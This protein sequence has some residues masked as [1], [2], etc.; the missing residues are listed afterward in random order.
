[1]DVVKAC[2][3]RSLEEVKKFTQFA[4]STDLTKALKLAIKK[5]YLEIVEY[6]ASVNVNTKIGIKI[7]FNADE[8]FPFFLACLHG[9]I[10]IV[11]FLLS[12]GKYNLD[13]PQWKRNM[14]GTACESGHL[15]LAEY[16]CS[17]WDIDFDLERTFV[18]CCEFGNLEMVEFLESLFNIHFCANVAFEAACGGGN[19]DIARFL[20]ENQGR[21]FD[22]PAAFYT[23]CERGKLNSMEFLLNSGL[24][25]ESYD[26]HAFANV[27]KNGHL[28]VVERMLE[29]IPDYR[30][31]M[32]ALDY[33]C[34]KSNLELIKFL[35]NQNLEPNAESGLFRCACG[36]RQTRIVEYLLDNRLN[37]SRFP[38]HFQHE[39][40]FYIVNQPGESATNQYLKLEEFE[41]FE[42]THIRKE[43]MSKCIDAFREHC[44]KFR[45]K[46]ARK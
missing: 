5:G 24:R 36:Y 38:F 15:E 16:F 34:K 12:L 45:G 39:F 4:S 27:C 7:D 11:E 43:H 6:F 9:Q 13:E 23:A 31:P 40:D 37:K 44:L 42:I 26:G 17:V 8:D 35:L 20:Q 21:S 19:P 46:S 33:A 18:N 32:I 29:Y 10:H 3:N 22:L 41:D 2:E 28:D 25:I 14:F 1:M 30:I